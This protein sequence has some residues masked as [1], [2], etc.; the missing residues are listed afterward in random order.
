MESVTFLTEYWQQVITLLNYLSSPLI[1]VVSI[2]G[3]Y[4]IYIAKKTIRVSVK[5]DGARQALELC[6]EKDAKLKQAFRSL[7]NKVGEDQI[8]LKLYPSR[9]G[10]GIHRGTTYC[11]EVQSQ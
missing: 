4:Q 3:L 1:L 10:M 2:I 11:F 9:S 8:E 6:S 5:R 7:K